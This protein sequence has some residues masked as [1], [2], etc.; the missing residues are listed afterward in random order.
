MGKRGH[1]K[2]AP[3]APFDL[4]RDAH[5]ARRSPGFEVGTVSL[6]PLSFNLD[7]SDAVQPCMS[8]PHPCSSQRS[9]LLGHSR[10]QP[11]R[12]R[13]PSRLLALALDRRGSRRDRSDRAGN[14]LALP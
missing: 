1:R 11:S 13:L 14:E 3:R 2:G 5:G 7:L 4:P 10:G 12:F 9:S 8:R 6:P